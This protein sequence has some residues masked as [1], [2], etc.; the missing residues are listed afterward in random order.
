MIAPGSLRDRRALEML[1]VGALFAYCYCGQMNASGRLR[2][3]S[4]DD[5]FRRFR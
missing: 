3:R 1:G 2:E 5:G 4:G